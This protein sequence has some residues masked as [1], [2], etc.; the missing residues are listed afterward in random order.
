MKNITGV[1]IAGGKSIRMQKD[2]ALM[3]YKGKKMATYSADLIRL[4]CNPVL[5]ASSN[6]GHAEFGDWLVKDMIG[7]GPIA[8]L[9][10]GLFQSTTLHNLVLPCDTPHMRADIL[11]KLISFK[12]DFEAVVAVD[13]NGKVHPLIGVYDK[14]IIGFMKEEIEAGSYALMN[15]LDKVNV[16]F[17]KFEETKAF[18]NINT[19]EDLK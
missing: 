13:A 17:V 16:K 8:G 5:V 6:A 15:I 2:K 14:R 4:F 18:Q 11:E 19:I 9:Y 1:L 12:D 7:A 10:A 3:L